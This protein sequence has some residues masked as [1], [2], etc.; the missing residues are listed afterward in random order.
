MDIPEVRRRV[1]AG[2]DQARRQASERRART[3]AASRDY[4]RLLSAQAIPAFNQL[5]SALVA[6]GHR[7][8][9]FTPAGSVRLASDSSS[10]DYLE[11]S[12]DSTEDP[13]IVIVRTNAGRGRRAI[14][15][16]RPLHPDTPIAELTDEQ[17]IDLVMEELTPLLER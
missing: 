16:E 3:D 11:L 12:L 6:E 17:I 4:E 15:K 5:A 1:R 13:P 8:K 9:V 14:T 2:I 10:D 7:F